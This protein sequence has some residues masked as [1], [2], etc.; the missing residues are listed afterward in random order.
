MKHIQ[1]RKSSIS[2]QQDPHDGEWCV[3]VGGM[4]LSDLAAL[5]MTMKQLSDEDTAVVR[6]L[7]K[8]A[9]SLNNTTI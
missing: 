9:H 1:A 2:L 4:V 5:H 3:L 8:V 7:G 6:S